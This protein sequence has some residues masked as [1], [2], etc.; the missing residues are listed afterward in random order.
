MR[1]IIKEEN[2]FIKIEE[3]KIKFGFFISKLLE[4]LC[5]R[6]E[7]EKHMIIDYNVI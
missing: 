1:Q 5:Q 6:I 7:R 2:K 3:H 4:Q